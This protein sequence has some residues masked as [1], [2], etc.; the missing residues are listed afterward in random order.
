MTPYTL[1]QREGK[2][3]AHAVAFDL[4]AVD[5]D[6]DEA[7]RKLRTLLIAQIGFG[8]RN[9]ISLSD[10]Y[11]AAPPEYWRPPF[12]YMDLPTQHELSQVHFTSQTSASSAAGPRDSA[13]G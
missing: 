1:V 7:V 9:G 6:R 10:I 5:K 13:A 11:F 12:E 4:V 8:R 3:V 2:W